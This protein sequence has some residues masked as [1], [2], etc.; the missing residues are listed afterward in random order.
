MKIMRHTLA[1]EKLESQTA[2]AVSRQQRD[3]WQQPRCQRFWQVALGEGKLCMKLSD[4][5]RHL[6]PDGGLFWVIAK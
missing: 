6:D 5:V 3:V 2:V 4:E 1:A